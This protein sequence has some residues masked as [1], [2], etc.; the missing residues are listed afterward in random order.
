MALQLPLQ[1][2]GISLVLDLKDLQLIMIPRRNNNLRGHI[3]NNSM[4]TNTPQ[5]IP[6][7]FLPILINNKY[8]ALIL[9]SITNTQT[10]Q[11]INLT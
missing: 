9:Q 5:I 6:N 7:N 8:L 10:S 1:I 3:I 11:M 4:T 2:D